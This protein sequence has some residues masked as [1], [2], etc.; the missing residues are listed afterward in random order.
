LDNT[1]EEQSHGCGEEATGAFFGRLPCLDQYEK[2]AALTYHKRAALLTHLKCRLIVYSKSEHLFAVDTETNMFPCRTVTDQNE[3]TLKELA[4]EMIKDVASKCDGRYQAGL[5]RV[6][7]VLHDNGREATLTVFP[8]C[9]VFP[10]NGTDSCLSETS[11]WT[12]E[13]KLSDQLERELARAVIA[14]QDR[15]RYLHYDVLRDEEGP[16]RC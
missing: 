3:T 6:E 11:R 10:L 7:H 14:D 2:T 5:L 15:E 13:D 4:D 12:T 8:V 16:K 1:G 9:H